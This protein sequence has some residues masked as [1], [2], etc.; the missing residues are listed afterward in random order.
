MLFGGPRLKKISW[1]VNVMRKEDCALRQTTFRGLW[2][3]EWIHELRGKPEGWIPEARISRDSKWRMPHSVGRLGRGPALNHSLPLQQGGHW[4]HWQDW[5]H[6]AMWVKACL[7]D[8]KREWKKWRQ[9]LQTPDLNHFTAKR[10]RREMQGQERAYFFPK[11]GA[12][13]ARVWCWWEWPSKG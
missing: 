13:T 6:G 12:I 3:V 7:G 1:G 4:W 10:S 8:L 9:W 11:L 5:L 2:E